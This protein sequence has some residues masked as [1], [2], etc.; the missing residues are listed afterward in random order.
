MYIHH[1]IDMYSWFQWAT[2]LSSEKVGCV[3]IHF[4]EIMPFTG[5]RA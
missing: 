3:I 2:A 1:T 4:L 5:I